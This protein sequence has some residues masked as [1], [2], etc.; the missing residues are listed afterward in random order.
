MLTGNGLLWTVTWLKNLKP[1]QQTTAT[2]MNADVERGWSPF[3]MS[4]VESHNLH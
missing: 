2:V 4:T 3:P 1:S